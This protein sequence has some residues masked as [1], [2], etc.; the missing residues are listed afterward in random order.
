MGERD[1]RKPQS[2]SD[3]ATA[4]TRVRVYR[5][6][7]IKSIAATSIKA[8]ITNLST[9]SD[10]QQSSTLRKRKAVVYN[11]PNLISKETIF[12]TSNSCYTS[13]S[14]SNN[15]NNNNCTLSSSPSSAY[16][17]AAGDITFPCVENLVKNYSLMI[18]KQ[19]QN[20][21]NEKTSSSSRIPSVLIGAKN[22]R[23]TNRNKSKSNSN[24]SDDDDNNFSC[25]VHDNNNDE[26]DDDGA[27]KT[28]VISAVTTTNNVHRGTIINSS[29]TTATFNDCCS[30]S[31]PTTRP[32]N[33][34]S[35]SP[36][37]IVN[38]SSAMSSKYYGK[39]NKSRTDCSDTSD[40]ATNTIV[41]IKINKPVSVDHLTIDQDRFNLNN[42]P[43]SDEGCLAN[44]SPYSSSSEDEVE[45]LTTNVQQQL[46]HTVQHLQCRDKVTRS[47]SSDSA[48]G[49][50]DEMIA[51]HQQPP[52]GGSVGRRLTLTVDDI[53]LR[54]ALLP[55]ASPK[56]LPDSPSNA[57]GTPTDATAPI[58]NIV[59]PSKVLL[60]GQLVEMPSSIGEKHSKHKT[61]WSSFDH[62]DQPTDSMRRVSYHG[63]ESMDHR[64]RYVRTPSVVVSDYSDDCMYNSITLDDIAFFRSQRSSMR[65]RSS[66]QHNTID[67]F[68][69]NL[70]QPLSAASS[71]SNFNFCGS[72]ISDLDTLCDDMF[73]PDGVPPPQRKTSDCST[74]SIMSVDEDPLVAL[75][76][77]K[78]S[79]KLTT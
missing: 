57:G 79:D 55:L 67:P 59:V 63:D 56:S 20:T 54:P 28:V 19:C 61:S 77:K 37:E 15:N 52:S 31:H 17:S 65:R 14:N 72:T 64:C 30:S 49:L 27:T 29:A 23:T 5:N 70:D 44:A 68:M 25:V 32:N 26:V 58:V 45:K 22:Q 38:K 43:L 10:Q 9:L 33:R 48:L 8:Q 47:S 66:L 3:G 21:I 62:H 16:I 50:D 35:R 11:R 71:C 78:V 24:I 75:D 60:E 6:E 41:S 51:E 36:T 46:K 7:Q 76:K 53:P 12:N 69:Y 39:T 42:S 1:L 4:V 34:N 13:T 18:Q 73:G 2:T 74:C 40:G